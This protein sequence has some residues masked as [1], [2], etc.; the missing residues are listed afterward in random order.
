MIIF[1]DPRSAEYSRD[2]HVD[3]PVRVVRSAQLLSYRH[4]EWEWREPATADRLTLLRAHTHDHLEAVGTACDDFDSDCP[5]YPEVFAHAARATGAAVEVGRAALLGEQAFSLMRPP[6]H[7]ATQDQPMGFCYFNHIAIAALDALDHGAGRVAIWD[8]D[9]HHGNGTE[10]I[11]TGHPRIAFASVH[12]FPGWPGTGVT[13]SGNIRNF[14]VAPRIGRSTHMYAIEQ[15]LEFLV[16][17]KPDL[18]LVSAGFDA[19]VDDPITEMTLEPEDF[20]T[21]G[22]WLRETGI[23]AGA[24]LEGGYS[25]ELPDL[26][27]NF[28]VGWTAR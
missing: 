18:I 19:Y 11:F 15:A 17:S 21:C 25:E 23:R 14:P 12:Q 13:S 4:P 9:A 16:F 5:A 6:G 8:F 24:I 1:H 20:A 3:T 2:G 10:A 22:R 28:L 26:I 27:D 7:H